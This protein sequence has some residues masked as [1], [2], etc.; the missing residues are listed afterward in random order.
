VNEGDIALALIAVRQEGWVREKLLPYLDDLGQRGFL[1]DPSFVI[2]AMVAVRRGT[3]RLK[4]VPREFWEANPDFDQGWEKTKKAINNVVRVLR[5]LGVLSADILPARNA[6]IPVFALD[7]LYANGDAAKLR[8]AFLWLLRA[9][10]DGRYSSS[11]ITTIAQDLAAIR[12]AG[13]FEKAIEALNS[14]FGLLLQ[15]K[16]DDMLLRYDEQPFLLLMLY[17]A[18]FE[19]KAEDWK[20][21]QRLGFDRSDNSLNDGFRPEWH[22]FVPRGRLKNREP[23]P[24]D[25]EVINCLAN[26]VVLGEGDNRRFSYSEPHKYLEKHKVPDTRVHQ[27]FFPPRDLWTADRFEDFVIARSTMLADAMNDYCNRLAAGQLNP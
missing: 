14:K 12:G 16:A 26:I 13:S 2:R 9:I 7:D 11:A 3:A 21:G 1:F 15:F 4:D 10:R 22:H 8:Q 20:T 6:L 23:T 5:E 17:L 25:D 27:Q 19:Q 18:A 24:P